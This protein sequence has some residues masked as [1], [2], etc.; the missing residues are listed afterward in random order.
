MTS[1]RDKQSDGFVP[2]PW[3]L[4]SAVPTHETPSQAT[5]R[6]DIQGSSSWVQ[7]I[8]LFSQCHTR[9]VLP[10][11]RMIAALA[12][13]LVLHRADAAAVTVAGSS[14]NELMRDAAGGSERWE[15][16]LQERRDMA[17]YVLRQAN[18]QTTEPKIVFDASH[19]AFSEGPDHQMVSLLEATMRRHRMAPGMDALA[20][21]ASLN[22]NWISSLRLMRLARESHG[23]HPIAEMYER[24]MQLAVS[25]SKSS[26]GSRPWKLALNLYAEC[27]AS[28]NHITTELHT[29]ALQALW[30]C[31]QRTWLAPHGSITTMH[32][33]MIW[34]AALKVLDAAHDAMRK[35]F[36]PG[37][38]R[39]RL[40]EAAVQCLAHGSHWEGALSL[41]SKMELAE[42][43]TTASLLAPTPV[44]LAECACALLRAGNFYQANLFVEL[45]GSYGYKWETLPAETLQSAVSMARLAARSGSTGFA[46]ML[47]NRLGVQPNSKVP[48]HLDRAVTLEC[49]QLIANRQLRLESSATWTAAARLVGSYD[50]NLW[51]QHPVERKNELGYLFFGIRRVASTCM[52]HSSGAS[53]FKTPH[54]LEQQVA[55][56]I[57]GIFGSASKEFEWWTHSLAHRLHTLPRGMPWEEGLAILANVLSSPAH[58]GPSPVRYLPLPMRQLLHMAAVNSWRSVDTRG[59]S[60]EVSPAAEEHDDDFGPQTPN[61]SGEAL[62]QRVSTTAA[63]IMNIIYQRR[64]AD[65]VKPW[66]TL[67]CLYMLEARLLH[68]DGR[69]AEAVHLA[70]RALCALG[71]APLHM[72]RQTS[73]AVVAD[74][75]VV[76]AQTTDQVAATLNELHYTL[77]RKAVP[78]RTIECFDW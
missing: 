47:L 46:M 48:L 17:R 1:P 36:V 62:R 37:E 38:E 65:H 74:A 56:W 18:R 59:G 63:C 10:T 64:Y 14:M 58:N 39:C 68:D 75:V 41:V 60:V 78:V 25:P 50:S 73:S 53:D 42:S 27:S 11:P 8:A 67:G 19:G 66:W 71:R 31:G 40:Y 6:R 70:E 69:L 43:D 9:D 76:L 23:V 5:L 15:V 52:Q 34:S 61:F 77:R 13:V 55:R 54:V 57:G 35:A 30:R 24:T 2:Q 32:K 22:V 16:T 33:E 20:D 3:L 72:S 28:G 29:R 51:P 45:F 26:F 49:L 4:P 44:T 21:L 7:A 12:D